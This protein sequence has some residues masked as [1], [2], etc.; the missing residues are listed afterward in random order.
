MVATPHVGALEL[1]LLGP[2]EAR[3]ASERLRIGGAKVRALL[4]DLLLHLGRPV[5]VDQL[6]DDLWGERPPASA[7]HAV[8]VYVSQLRNTLDPDRAG[9][10]AG[11][12]AGY[13]LVVDPERVDAY[14]FERLLDKGRASLATGEFERAAVVLGEALALWRGPA[15]ADFTYEPFAQS[16]IARLEELRVQ[17]MEERLDAD[18]G[19]GRHAELVPELN[20]LV[21][22]HPFR[23][24]LRGQ[25]MRALYGSG[26]QAE[27]LAAYRSAREVLLAEL[28]VEPSP[29]LRALEAAILRQ[30]DEL[31]ASIP[32]AAK[33]RMPEQ[34]KLATI[35]FADIVESTSLA[36]S[37]DPET[38]RRALERYFDLAA[39]VLAEHGGTMKRFIGDAVVAAFGVPVAHE[40]DALRASRAALELREAMAELN[41]GLERN[42]GMWLGLRIGLAS[43]EVVAGDPEEGEVFATGEAVNVATRLAETAAVGEIVIGELTQ[44]LIAHAA[45]LEPVGELVLRGS[46]EAVNA[47]RLLDVAPGAP[48]HA[49]RLDAPLIGRRGELERLRV[50]FD[51]AVRAVDLAAILVLGPAGIGKSRLA[52]ELA[53]ELS[54]ELGDRATVVE[55]RCPAYGAGLALAPVRAIVRAVAGDE[56]RDA[57]AAACGDATAADLLAAAFGVTASPPAEEIAWAFRLFCEAV[58]K[59]RPLVLVLEDLHWAEIALLDLL[60]HLAEQSMGA[61]ILVVCLAREELLEERPDLLG[62]CER[63]VLDGLQADETKRLIDALVGEAV[64][65]EEAR[66]R[67]VEAAEGNP[68]F[69]EQL[70]ALAVDQGGLDPERPLPAT[71]QALLLARLDRLGPAERA[72]LERAAVVGREF[73]RSAVVELLDPNA[74]ETVRR[75]I[76]TLIRRGF[77]DPVPSLEPFEEAFRF[78][79]VLIQAAVYGA[80]PKGERARLHEQHAKRLEARPETAADVD[81]VL[82]YHLERAHRY[83]SELGP[84]DQ[85]ARELAAQAGTRLASAGLRAWKGS[86]ARAATDLLQRAT[87]LLPPDDPGRRE[88]LCELGVAERMAGESERAAATLKGAAEFFAAAGDRRAELR[89]R[90]ELAY[91][92]LLTQPGQTA[93]KLLAVAEEAIPV[94]EETGDD[95]ALGRAWLLCGFVQGGIR[96]QNAAWLEAAERALV[97]HRNS[98]WPTSSCLGQIAA[99]LYEGPTPVTSAIERCAELIRDSSA[100][101]GAEANVLVFVGGLEA[102]RG[103]FDTGREL[104]RSAQAVFDDL[105][106]KA[107]STIHCG[108][109]AGYIAFLAGDPAEAERSLRLTCEELRRVGDSAHL[110]SR[111]A[112]LAEALYAQEQYEEAESWTRE[113]ER[114]AGR[115]DLTAQ[116]AWRS[117]RA[118]V[119]ARRDSP[120]QALRL[121]RAA[122]RLVKDTDGLNQRAKICLDLAQVLR[123]AGLDEEAATQVREALRLFDLKG[124]LAGRAAA[125]AMNEQVGSA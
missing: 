67:I 87:A 8:E 78:R 103:R 76:E 119:L 18:L 37:V 6:V 7:A 122:L 61:P 20:A 41:E 46:A 56:S 80:T 97:H 38:Q 2:L 29:A 68:L 120:R 111:A 93:D 89:A 27:A 63:L 69:L 31:S 43:G 16:A 57:I 26:R 74:A 33:A 15:L 94:F 35:L 62:S 17:A 121:A 75:H 58:A 1:R 70:V 92:H 88:V 112:D 23:E 51:R 40:D 59:R 115:D 91:V 118:K 30:D 107:I 116:P 14:R 50:A 54:G 108:A 98:G 12:P 48:S 71:I 106:Q 60:E 85:H 100:D 113:S 83:L 47:F 99:A 72:V 84:V 53:T 24:R 42:F 110:A 9:L 77:I 10:I 101:R 5:S 28:G 105:G 64:L 66:F 36:G 44:R 104:V 4:A 109:M 11:R 73:R 123:L 96:C 25:L 21:V 39:T 45:R 13:A 114:H 86:D 95:R 49:R 3:R 124:N 19:T 34:R 55:G 117:V 102:Q 32:H 79:H 90:L 82:G 52:A 65:S 81:A 22:E 125:Q